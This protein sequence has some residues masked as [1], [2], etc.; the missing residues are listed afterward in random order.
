MYLPVWGAPRFQ[1]SP[2]CLCVCSAPSGQP[3]C[4]TS[5]CLP[6]C[7]SH[8]IYINIWRHGSHYAWRKPNTAFY[9]KN[10]IPTV[11]HGSG[12]VM[13]WGYFADSG[14]GR[15]A[16]LVEGTMNS[17][18]YQRIL[19]ENVRPYVCELKHSWVMQQDND[20]IQTIKAWKWL[21]SNKFEVLE[22]PSQSTDLISIGMLWQTLKQA[23]HPWKPT[24][25]VELK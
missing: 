8:S 18:L 22:W 4:Q 7:T 17:A 1:K 5:L 16:L 21:K 11:K 2:R 14:P 20:P 23:V 13:V 6:P 24:N 25:V 3:G 15:L 19:L 10:P 12:S 9:S